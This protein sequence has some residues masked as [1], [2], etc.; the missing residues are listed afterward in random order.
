MAL[1]RAYENQ[2]YVTLLPDMNTPVGANAKKTQQRKRKRQGLRKTSNK[3]KENV[4][5]GQE[6]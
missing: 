3:H 2:S 4:A 6:T 5:K 1:T